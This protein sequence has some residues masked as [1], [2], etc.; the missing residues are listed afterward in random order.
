MSKGVSG[1][2]LLDCLPGDKAII[3]SPGKGQASLV[4]CGAVATWLFIG[5]VAG[6]MAGVIGSD[7]NDYGGGGMKVSYG[8]NYEII[9]W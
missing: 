9:H 3:S 1:L 5:V 4:S 2:C 8:E 6:K 7:G